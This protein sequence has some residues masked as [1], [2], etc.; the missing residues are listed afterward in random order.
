MIIREGNNMFIGGHV[1]PNAAFRTAWP[2]NS[3][4][5]LTRNTRR[6]LTVSSSSA[7]DEE[8]STGAQ[9]VKVQ[10]LNENLTYLENFIYLNGQT[11]VSITDGFSSISSLIVLNT[12]STGYN[13]GIIYVGEGTVTAGVPATVYEQIAIRDGVSHTVR[14]TVPNR[15]TLYINKISVSRPSDKYVIVE[16]LKHIENH[17]IVMDQRAYHEGSAQIE[18]S[19]PLVVKSGEVFTVEVQAVGGSADITYVEV[20]AEER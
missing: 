11:P 10:G 14:Y 9:Y 4:I 13:E 12:G 5:P 2:G 15:K 20:Y 8:K 18:Y 3:I 1:V 16:A 7:N 6:L 17:H 19:V